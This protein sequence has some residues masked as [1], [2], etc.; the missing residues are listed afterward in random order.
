MEGFLPNTRA[1]VCGLTP[2]QFETLSRICMNNESGID[3]QTAKALI[4]RRLVKVYEELMSAGT[5][6]GHITR[7]RA[8]SIYVHMAWCLICSQRMLR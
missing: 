4:E 6:R 3:P 1:I 8:A 2:H 7:Y 5:M